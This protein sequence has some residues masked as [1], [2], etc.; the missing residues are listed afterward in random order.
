[1]L[2]GARFL[3][4]SLAAGAFIP[5]L[6]PVAAQAR[7]TGRIEG[8]VYDSIAAQPLAGAVVQL[9]TPDYVE[10]RVTTADA[11]GRFRVDS[12]AVGM[13]VVGALHAQLDS[14]GISQ[15]SQSVL[16]RARARARVVL[17]VPSPAAL[18]ARTCSASAMT[19]SEGYVR[20]SLRDVAGQAG[21]GTVWF[22]WQE[23]QL[24]GDGQLEHRGSG[25]EATVDSLGRFVACGVPANSLVFVRGWRG[26][27]STGLLELRTPLTGIGVIELTTGSNLASMSSAAVATGDVSGAVPRMVLRGAGRLEGLA[28]STTGQPVAGAQVT[29]WGSGLEVRADDDGRFA[30]QNLPVGSFTIEARAVGY[31]PIRQ[32][33]T[34]LPNSSVQSELIFTRNVVLDTLKVSARSLSKLG[35]ELADFETRRRTHPFRA[36]FFGPEEL[37]KLNPVRISDVF[38]QVAGVRVQS[39]GSIAMRGASFAR[40]CAPVLYVDGSRIERGIRL[41]SLLDVLAV[42]AIEVYPT[43][44]SSPQQFSAGMSGCGTIVIWTGPRR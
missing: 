33:V 18:I 24:R 2:S 12:L 1:M 8:V 19:D 14:L 41:E 42:R 35:P 30:M 25:I 39:N 13:W 6:A 7:A 31:D 10:S 17:A 3:A 34:L 44:V 27:D 5:R 15:L 38:L 32:T 11:K 40:W 22:A 16:V 43:A 37:E 23:V 36:K 9:L 4:I 29:V 21:G 28:R 26:A 20:G